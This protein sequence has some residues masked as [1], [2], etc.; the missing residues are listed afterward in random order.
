MFIISENHYSFNIFNMHLQHLPPI[1]SRVLFLEMEEAPITRKRNH[2]LN[3]NPEHTHLSPPSQEH[4]HKHKKEPLY[5]SRK[6]QILSKQFKFK[7]NKNYTKRC[8]ENMN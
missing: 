1:T 3:Y 5:S 7:N 6:N 8:Q 2:S 4:T